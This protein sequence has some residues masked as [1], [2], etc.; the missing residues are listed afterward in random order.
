MTNSIPLELREAK[1][2]IHWKWDGGLKRPYNPWGNHF[3]SP[4]E[5]AYWNT[6]E[7]AKSYRVKDGGLGFALKWQDGKPNFAVVDLDDCMTEFGP[8]KDALEMIRL[9]DSYTEVSPS[10]T[11]V[12]IFCRIEQPVKSVKT[13]TMEILASVYA[14]VTGEQVEGY[15]GCSEQVAERT[16]W[17]QEQSSRLQFLKYLDRPYGTSARI[18][19]GEIVP[20]GTRNESLFKHACSLRAEG[21][22]RSEIEDALLAL[23]RQCDPP[24]P[25]RTVLTIARS[26]S[27]YKAGNFE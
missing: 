19:D 20:D 25:E 24:L 26:A 5:P 11:G 21:L 6:F 16:L 15:P 22:D 7:R 10:G 12:K 23:N 13:A 17:L 8:N 1:R 2:W 3:I 9:T 27:G 4:T 14:T 18:G